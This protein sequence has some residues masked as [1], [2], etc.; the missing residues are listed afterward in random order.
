M[1]TIPGPAALGLSI[2][3]SSLA[4]LSAAALA[5]EPAIVIQSSTQPAS[6]P[7]SQ[8]AATRSATPDVIFWRYPDRLE[9]RP[10][11]MPKAFRR[12]QFEF[13]IGGQ[14][15][16]ATGRNGTDTV[17]FVTT[18]F[19][20]YVADGLSLGVEGGLAPGTYRHHRHD[21]DSDRE[22][23]GRR[24]SYHL[25]AE[26]VMGLARWHFL[27][28]DPLSLYIDAGLGGLHASH[29]FPGTG[30]V[31]NWLWAA[32]GGLTLRLDEHWFASAGPALR[33]SA[34]TIC[35]P[36]WAADTPRMECNTMVDSRSSGERRRRVHRRDAE[37][38]EKIR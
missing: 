19:G 26:E 36:T 24:D 35:S 6:Q 7:T 4:T 2:L 16:S 29:P 38:A 22:D 30:R 17:G 10:E 15:F 33:D 13:E 25:R 21:D 8:P 12:H 23:D 18:T 28:A 1:K 27:R 3:V 20:Y 34:A 14:G 9:A 32:G 5:D 11:P 37:N 31:D